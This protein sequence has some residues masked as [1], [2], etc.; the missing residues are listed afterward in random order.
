MYCLST[1]RVGEAGL[2][3]IDFRLIAVLKICLRTGEGES[4][5]PKNV[6]T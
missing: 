1:Y 5:K 6:L 2:K 4:K 3:G